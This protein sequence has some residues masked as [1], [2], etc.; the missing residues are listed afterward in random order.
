MSDVGI[1]SKLRPQARHCLHVQ[2]DGAV[3]VERTEGRFA[4]RAPGRHL[5][6]QRARDDRRRSI[7]MSKASA[8]FEALGRQ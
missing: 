3:G 5:E 6:R 2:C 1:L 4:D 7:H 8:Q